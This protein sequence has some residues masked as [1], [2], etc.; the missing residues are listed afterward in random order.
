[1]Q[2]VKL[3]F[4][5]DTITIYNKYEGKDALTGKTFTQYLRTVLHNCT[6]GKSDAVMTV[7]SVTVGSDDYR[8]QIPEDDAFL[9]YW[10]W[11]KQPNDLMGE[12]FTVSPGDVVVRGE[13]EDE[14]PYNTSPTA[15][16]AKYKERAFTARLV[17]NHTGAE[18]PLGHYSLQG[19]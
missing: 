10:E 6:W 17:F 16:L 8:V 9:D 19:K 4:A 3:P 7:G 2:L 12:Y 1:M 11:A 14:I 15:L 13:V 18:K 5:A